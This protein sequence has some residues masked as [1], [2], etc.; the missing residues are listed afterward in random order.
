MTEEARPTQ[1]D[2]QHNIGQVIEQRVDQALAFGIGRRAEGEADRAEPEIEHAGPF[3]RLEIIVPLR[4][5]LGDD[6]DLAAI[7]AKPLIDLFLERLSRAFPPRS[8][9][10]AHRG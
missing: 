3:R 2:E 10:H 4:G 1:G 6:V 8:E 9:S 5:C 7:E